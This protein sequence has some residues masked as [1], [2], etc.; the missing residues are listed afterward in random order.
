MEG[1]R[2]R[3]ISI[4]SAMPVAYAGSLLLVGQAVGFNHSL[5]Q[6]LL[7][8]GLIALAIGMTASALLRVEIV[9]GDREMR[10][11]LWWSAGPLTRLLR[12]M[13]LVLRLG[14][15]LSCG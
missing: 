8:A 6:W 10:R 2:R 1:T 9:F 13:S 5:P 3:I 4:F 11:R 12:A 14:W 7:A 15:R